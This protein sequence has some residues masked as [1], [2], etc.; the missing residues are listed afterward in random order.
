M[1]VGKLFE[2]K[3]Y[4]VLVRAMA[5]VIQVC[6]SAH[7]VLVGTGPQLLSLRTL[8]AQ[9][10]IDSSVTLMGAVDREELPRLLA[11]AQVFCHPASS[12]TFP[13]APLEAMACG[14]PTVVSSAGALPDLVGK[15]G[16]VYKVNDDGDLAR[17]LVEVL[18]KPAL[19]ERLGK[20]GRA[21]VQ[22]RFTWQAMCDSYLDLYRRLA[23]PKPPASN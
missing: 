6:P 19:G 13:L 16:I 21:R 3:G 22:A 2:R 15:S 7:L 4:D 12:D 8:A 11:S 23:Q 20:S 17:C 10:R 5:R 9:L 14:V 18:G 1:A